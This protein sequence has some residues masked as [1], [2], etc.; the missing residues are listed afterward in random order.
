MISLQCLH[1]LAWILA[2]GGAIWM[3]RVWFAF[4]TRAIMKEAIEASE[5]KV[6]A[7]RLAIL[8]VVVGLLM[9][10]GLSILEAYDH[11]ESFWQELD[12]LVVCIPGML[13]LTFFGFLVLLIRLKNDIDKN[14]AGWSNP[15]EE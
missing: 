9:G 7:K 10:I 8:S 6:A 13:L 11:P 2:I 4:G 15:P 14:V 3:C 5:V 1:P 12:I